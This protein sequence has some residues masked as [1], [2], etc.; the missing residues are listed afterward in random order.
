MIAAAA[1]L[2]LACSHIEKTD[3]DISDFDGV[4]FVSHWTKSETVQ[5]NN[6]EYREP[7]A[8]GSATEIIVR[9]NHEFAY[10]K[11]SGKEAVIVILVTDPGG[12]GTFHDL[13]LLFKEDG[14]WVNK[15]LK[16]LGD[17]VEV[18]DL[19]MEGNL[20]TVNLITHRPVD[21]MCCP[22][23]EKKLHYTIEEDQLVEMVPSDSDAAGEKLLD[24]EWRWQRTLYNDDRKSIPPKPENYTLLLTR[25]DRISARIDCNRGGGSYSLEDS[26]IT[27]EITH[28]TMAACPPG[29]LDRAFLKDLSAA[30]IYFIKNGDLYID[31]KYDTG[32]MKFSK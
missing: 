32:T 18:Q 7:A 21:P 26:R 1:V 24:I 3:L 25:N 31:L 8:P 12:S 13:A 19:S 17:R 2:V 14:L 16:T 30:A 9:L 5:L 27:I 10:G 28:M 15:D 23:L 4:E 6:G 29:S 11:I 22:T 20:I